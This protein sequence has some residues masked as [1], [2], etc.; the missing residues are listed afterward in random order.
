[1]KKRTVMKDRSYWCISKKNVAF[2]FVPNALQLYGVRFNWKILFNNEQKSES[3]N[4]SILIHY[5]FTH[6]KL[7]NAHNI[8]TFINLVDDTS[9]I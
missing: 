5:I 8:A 9:N 6:K 7:S 3:F 2:G 1:M 4:I